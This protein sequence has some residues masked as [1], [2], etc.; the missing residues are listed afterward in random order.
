[1]LAGE[2]M[3]GRGEQGVGELEAMA[4]RSGRRTGRGDAGRGGDAGGHEQGG[5]ELGAM[6]SRSGRRTR[7]GRGAGARLVTDE[8]GADKA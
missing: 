1:M 8:H 6:A 2:E 7:R 4:S 3:R 5:G